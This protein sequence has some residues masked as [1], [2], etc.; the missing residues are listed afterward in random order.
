MCGGVFA[1]AVFGLDVGA[2]QVVVGQTQ[3]DAVG[4]V[5]QHVLALG[6]ADDVG[7][8]QAVVRP[9]LGVNSAPDH[10][11]IDGFLDAVG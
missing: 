8:L 7:V 3:T 9:R 6:A 5:R 1:D 10:D 2:A 4:E 11:R